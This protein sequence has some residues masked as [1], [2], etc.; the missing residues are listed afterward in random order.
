MEE[1]ARASADANPAV[2]TDGLVSTVEL[3]R[4]ADGSGMARLEGK[5]GERKG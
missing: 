5:A 2:R 1:N 4:K 3:G